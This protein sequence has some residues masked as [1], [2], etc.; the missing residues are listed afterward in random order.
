MR[1]LAGISCGQSGA[2]RGWHISVTVPVMQSMSSGL[3]MLPATASGCVL[4]PGGRRPSDSATKGGRDPDRALLRVCLIRMMWWLGAPA[5][6]LLA[7]GALWGP[8]AVA[9]GVGQVRDG[10]GA[11]VR[12]STQLCMDLPTSAFPALPSGCFMLGSAGEGRVMHCLTCVDE[13][14]SPEGLAVCARGPD[15]ALRCCLRRRWRPSSSWRTST[16]LS[17]TVCSA[18]A[19]GLAGGHALTA[20]CAGV[21]HGACL[22][23]VRR[24]ACRP[25][26]GH[27][28]SL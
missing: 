4:W 19:R 21:P 7:V 26:A 15:Q 1:M 22:S 23:F 9:M 6:L 10:C 5:G 12:H 20:T 24:H 3:A 27:Y 2:R 28:G 8:V 11:A 18:R 14:S 13:E 25:R 17:T 16:T